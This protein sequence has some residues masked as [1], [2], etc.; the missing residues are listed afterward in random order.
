MLTILISTILRHSCGRKFCLLLIKFTTGGTGG[1]AICHLCTFLDPLL[2]TQSYSNIFSIFFQQVLKFSL[3]FSL[4][5]S[6]FH[7]DSSKNCFQHL[8]RRE[9]IFHL[10]FFF[11][12]VFTDLPVCLDIS[13]SV[14]PLKPLKNSKLHKTHRSFPFY[15]TAVT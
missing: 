3:K 13:T 4:H 9:K 1:R 5:F 8:F 7:R 15:N 12:Y 6:Q 2:I 14:N 11:V 10:K